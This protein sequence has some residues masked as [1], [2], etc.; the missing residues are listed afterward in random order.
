VFRYEAGPCGYGL[1]RYLTGRGF[2]CRVVA[3][4][5]IARELIVAAKQCR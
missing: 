1:P 5:A 4:T 2:D 3:V